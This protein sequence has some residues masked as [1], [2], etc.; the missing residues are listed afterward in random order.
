MSNVSNDIKEG[1]RQ[2]YLADVDAIRNLSSVATK[3]QAGG[4][5]VPGVLK[6]HKLNMMDDKWENVHEGDDKSYIVS[7][8]TNYKKLMLVGNNKGGGVRRVGVWDDMEVSRNLQVNG[9]VNTNS[10]LLEGG[11][12]LMPAGVIV[13][14]YGSAV[15]SGWALCDGTNGTPDLR[16]RFV[17]G[18]TGPGTG[19][20]GGSATS[21]FALSAQNIP[22]HTHTYTNNYATDCRDMRA[23]GKGG[24]WMSGPP[25]TNYPQTDGGNFSASSNGKSGGTPVTL[26]II[27]PYYTLAYIM[28]K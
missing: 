14:W 19:S 28:K 9:T 7:D 13:V 15:P 2:V 22:A 1:I 21:T 17:Y 3:L 12:A 16:N 10:K 25:G 26:S 5:T 4:I 8:N 11:N 24:C 6:T 20:A 18:A 27:P 23:S